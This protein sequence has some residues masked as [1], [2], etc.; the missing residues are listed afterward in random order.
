M[1]TEKVLS[2]DKLTPDVVRIIISKPDG[3]SFTPGQAT[4]VSINKEYWATEKR[5]F[6]FTSLP[7]DDHLEFIIKTYPSHQG[8]TNQLLHIKPEDELIIGDPW[9]AITYQ[10]EGVFIAGGAGIT[11]FISIFR[12]LNKTNRLGQNKLLFANRRKA[13]IILENELHKLLGNKMINILSE[14]NGVGCLSGFITRDV[15]REYC[16]DKNAV[17]YVCGPPPMMD[18]VLRGLSDLH[19]ADQA[20]VTEI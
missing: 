5:P 14:E 17:F 10:G 8:V 16:C 9:G 3:Y 18:L 15:L 20:V 7:E 19:I 1:Y 2:V 12:D 13:D 11:P 4:E 6:T